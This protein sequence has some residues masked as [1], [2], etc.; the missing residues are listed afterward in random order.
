MYT[1]SVDTLQG[2]LVGVLHHLDEGVLQDVFSQL[3]IAH[4]PLQIPQEQPVVLE[5]D[6]ERRPRLI[7]RCLRYLHRPEYIGLRAGVMR[8]RAL[9]YPCEGRL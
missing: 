5:Q 3:A 2:H 8:E 1:R 9:R 4:P 6:V 7:R